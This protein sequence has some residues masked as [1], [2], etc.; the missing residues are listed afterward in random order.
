[1]SI[2]F[3]P[4]DHLPVG[5][6]IGGRN[7]PHSAQG[8]GLRLT[9]YPITYSSNNVL[10]LTMYDDK[11]YIFGGSEIYVYG[12]VGFHES[13]IFDNSEW[14][15]FGVECK[16][17]KLSSKMGASNSYPFTIM[18]ISNSSCSNT[19]S[20]SAMSIF[21]FD[22]KD[23]GDFVAG[24][25]FYLEMSMK[26]GPT[27]DGIAKRWVNGRRLSD[28]HF[29]RADELELLT[30]RT[31]YFTLIS[32]DSFG[33]R[34]IYLAGDG[35]P[36]PVTKRIGPISEQRLELEVVTANDWTSNDGQTINEFLNRDIS[37]TAPYDQYIRTDSNASLKYKVV[38]D[39]LPTL[40]MVGAVGV[41]GVHKDIGLGITQDVN[42]SATTV[43]NKDNQRIL[44][45]QPYILNTIFG[46]DDFNKT[47]FN[48]ADILDLTI[49][50]TFVVT[51]ED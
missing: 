34:N 5:P 1:M 43:L 12:Q 39:N 49:E 13:N 38:E 3:Y 50:H 44:G 27:A 33:Y 29:I 28:Q 42:S 22:Y 36:K 26:I 40:P 25:V 32:N 35:L 2:K 48:A 16:I 21:V 23:L 19:S 11:K 4:L 7:I 10:N 18:R 8:G 45:T 17:I 14:I 6:V 20:G 24:D 41:A 15:F 30:N 37:N 47:L 46:A 31:A 51:D 9:D